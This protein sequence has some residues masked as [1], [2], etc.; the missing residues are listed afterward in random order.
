MSFNRR[1]Y[2]RGRRSCQESPMTVL[3]DLVVQFQIYVTGETTRSQRA[4]SNLLTLLEMY[5][6][7]GYDLE[8]IDISKHPEIAEA[9]PV[10]ATPLV[11]RTSPV[12]RRVI[13]DLS[14]FEL[15][16]KALG[17]DSTPPAG[18]LA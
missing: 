2:Q 5:L 17:L 1:R 15:A 13:G 16:A 10:I 6:P 8:V 14:D 7:H 4:I 18:R 9:Q 3:S 12:A 11:M